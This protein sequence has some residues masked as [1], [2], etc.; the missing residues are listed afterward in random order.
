MGFLDLFR[1]AWKSKDNDKALEAIKKLTDNKKLEY[2]VQNYTYYD[3]YYQRRIVAAAIY[4]I[5]DQTFLAKIVNGYDREL[6]CSANIANITDEDILYKT[7]TDYQI[8]PKLNISAITEIINKL[9]DNSLLSILQKFYPLGE[10]NNEYRNKY[11]ITSLLLSQKLGNRQR[12]LFEICCLSD[13]TVDDR[14]K[15]FNEIKDREM[16]KNIVLVAS[17]RNYRI[18][19]YDNL[20]LNAYNAIKELAFLAFEKIEEQESLAE[21]VCSHKISNNREAQNFID[22]I[23][24]ALQEITD[25]DLLFRIAKESVGMFGVAA[26]AGITDKNKLE[27]LVRSVRTETIN[28]ERENYGNVINEEVTRTYDAVAKAAFYRLKEL[29]Y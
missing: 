24:I 22:R 4:N 8:Y 27:E 15:A 11:H 2:I 12:E 13:N 20:E 23:V 14:K 6:I 3:Y 25:E 29:G 9:N 18:N 10:P 16:L 21:I 28:W 7:L 26:V 1:P 5:T 19:N 17:R